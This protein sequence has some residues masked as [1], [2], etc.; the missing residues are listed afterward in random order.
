MD[1]DVDFLKIADEKLTE[2]GFKVIKTTSA[3]DTIE[4][5]KAVYVDSIMIL[6][7]NEENIIHDFIK[8]LKK[9]PLIL[10]NGLPVLNSFQSLN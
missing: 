8:T 10:D 4:I 1:Q 2:R 3:R 9:R 5:L 6:N 7:K